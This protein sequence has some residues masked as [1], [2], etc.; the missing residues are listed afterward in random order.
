MQRPSKVSLWAQ[1]ATLA[2]LFIVA[3]PFHAAPALAQSAGVTLDLRVLVVSRG[4]LASNSL[5][6]E[7]GVLR[8]MTD[9]LS[10]LDV[11]YDL[12]DAKNDTFYA[13]GDLGQGVPGTLTPGL[14]AD[15]SHGYYNGVILTN[16][17][18][19]VAS[20]EFGSGLTP[21][22]WRVL[23]QY[24][25]D[26]AVRESVV[27]GWPADNAA[28]DLNYGLNCDGSAVTALSPVAA[29]W[30]APAGGKEYFEYVNTATPLPISD[31][32]LICAP[33]SGGPQVQPLL[34]VDGD[35]AKALVSKLNY[36]DG[37]EV[38]ISTI[39]NAWFSLHSQVL[40]YEFVNFATK[41]LFVGARKVHFNVHLD[42]LFLPDEM[43]DST[44]KRNDPT[45]LY[46]MTESDVANAVALQD[47]LRAQH[48]LAEKF[49]LD[50]AFNAEKADI[51]GADPLSNAVVQSKDSFR[52]I[53]HTF[54]HMDMDSSN[55]EATY[56]GIVGEILQNRAAWVDLGLP[57]ATKNRQVLVTG[58]HSGLAYYG[59][60]ST[61]DDDVP[62]PQGANVNLLKA[63]Q[64]KG[65]RFL[66]ADSSRPNQ[67]VEAYVPGYNL[68]LL[69]RWPTALFFNVTSP[70]QWLDEYNWVFHA[71]YLAQ[72]VDPCTT[73]GALCQPRSYQEM[74]AA[75]GEANLRH[76]LTYKRWPYYM[77]QSNL[78]IHDAA[79]CAQQPCGTLLGDW[80][81][82]VITQYERYMTLP[83]VSTPYH[84]IGRLTRERL[85]ARQATVKA[86]W[87]PAANTVTLLADRNVRIQMTGL[88]GGSLYGGQRQRELRLYADTPATYTVNRALNR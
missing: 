88:S 57:D 1:R 43:W 25:R 37:R 42:D 4:A 58:M 46:R 67:N 78:A 50:F 5:D 80:L 45:A 68:I 73:P 79:G 40:A 77:H 83:L 71:R 66:A 27:S 36:D 17:E 60:T 29:K 33:T 28:L 18:L 85:N 69:P 70:A 6:D 26:F 19:Y 81:E 72:G 52:F 63:A 51:S 12:L 49:I 87:D 82:A 75:E 32:A 54:T 48:P 30:R 53:N 86:T 59:D 61:P 13:G 10:E 31:F 23:H 55:P 15:G 47:M 35:T 76:L 62:Y 74:L 20:A 44:A 41:G 11:P 22:E 16:A 3:A 39:E 34:T 2:A 7:D 14:L 8:L 65:V 24:E 56:K 64:S 84:Q 9:L 21:Q 38:L